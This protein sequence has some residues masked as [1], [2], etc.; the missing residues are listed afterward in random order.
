MFGGLPLNVERNRGEKKRIFQNLQDSAY[1]SEN[2]F[3]FKSRCVAF[4]KFH[5][6]TSCHLAEFVQLA[7]H[8]IVS[9]DAFRELFQNALSESLR[10][11]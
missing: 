11:T 1:F 8:V 3:S 4:A 5:F 6:L 9:E 7:K 10:E 2:T